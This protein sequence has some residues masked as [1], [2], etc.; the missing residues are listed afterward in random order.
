MSRRFK[1]LAAAL[2]IVALLAIGLT[3]VAFA[4]SPQATGDA[5][6]TSG[7][8]HGWGPCPGI[9]FPMSTAVSDL[10]RLT[11]QQN[12]EQQ[13]QGKSL[14][15]IAAAQGVDETILTNAVLAA[16]KDALQQ[17]VA[18]GALTQAQ[19]DQMLEQFKGGVS[20]Y[21]NRTDSGPPANEPG[22]GWGRGSR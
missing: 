4:D 14:V 15:Q 5:A 6:S 3:S 18:N 7:A 1:L 16:E 11:P 17:K 12:K 22:I 13:H 2:A 9:G 20:S 8:R 10:L 19:A 21:L